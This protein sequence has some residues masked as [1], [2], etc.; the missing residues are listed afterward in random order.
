MQ[1]ANPYLAGNFAP[2]PDERT[3]RD[4]PVQGTLP[5]ELSGQLLRN[6][7]NPIAVPDPAGYDWSSGDGMVHAIELRDGRAVTYRN[8]WVRT[9]AACDLLGEEPAPGQPPD[10]FPGN[11]ANTS[12]VVHGG[13]I[14][15]LAELCLPTALT[16]DLRTAGRFDFGGRLRGAMTAHPK[17]DPETGE[18][19]FFGC[20]PI[21][22]PHLRL[23]VVD[24]DGT[25]VR[26]D[27]INLPG[28]AV[29]H[30]FAVTRRRVV[31]LDL[32]VR[33]DF[34]ALAGGA[35]RPVVWRPDGGARVGVMERNEPGIRWYDSGGVRWCDVEPCY[36]SHVLNAYD[37]GRRVVLDVIRYAWLSAGGDDPDPTLDR[38]TVD[39]GTGTVTQERID[40][41]GLEL[42]RMD[43]R[44]AGR[45]HRYGYT[46]QFNCAGGAAR[47]G[48]LV[49]HDL[50]AG[51]AQ[52]HDPGPDRSA[53][54]GVFVAAGPGEDEGYVLSV[55]YDAGR[56]GSDLVVVDA[57]DFSGP[58]VATVRLPRRVPY[59]FHGCWI[60]SGA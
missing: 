40:S 55:V 11:V 53:G 58:P 26:C 35:R 39:T 46:T 33:Y 54:E 5:P 29:M 12:V 4:L 10:V 42:P 8:R 16:A 57:T 50:A 43:D 17:A 3:D 7:P 24:A 41:R 14:L 25:L 36:V 45:P 31:F 34:S 38:W 51:T 22:E 2:V 47:F 23:H 30:D 18:L 27:N 49:K 37:D 59:G 9:D 13:R 15:A 56:D 6:G 60:P 20:D 28:P 52:V 1:T 44:R 48:A 19:L 32:P 21:G